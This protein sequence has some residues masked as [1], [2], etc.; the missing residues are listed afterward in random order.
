[1]A[2]FADDT[3]ILSAS[4]NPTIASERLQAHLSELQLWINKWRMK[5]NPTKS[6]QV[7]FAN[8]RATCPVVMI[9]DTQLPVSN[10]V[11]Y[12]GLVLDSKLTWR[13]HITSKKTHM[14]LKLR[15][16]NWL[17]GR[18]SK[19]STEN[20]LLLYKTIIKPISTYGIQLWGCS[21]PSNTKIIQRAQS[22]ALRIIYN[23]PWYVSNKTLHDD[24]NLA[25]I[26]DEIQRISSRYLERLQDHPNEE[27]EQL[28]VPPD[29]I[30]RLRRCWPTDVAND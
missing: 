20:K 19:L 10:Q 13:A 29:V 2:T 23:A 24:A 30:R 14:N 3:A 16:M 9:G 27:A 11:K 6:V 26:P 12:L 15:Q 7:T 22:R 25:Y 21:K 28:R 17:I 5:I 4:E 1:M 8:R 18:K